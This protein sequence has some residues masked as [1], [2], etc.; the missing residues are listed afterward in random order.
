MSELDV[1]MHE[2]CVCGKLVPVLN[3]TRVAY[4]GIVNSVSVL[5]DDCNKE[6]AESC[7]LVCIGCK[8]VIGRFDPGREPSGFVFSKRS[9]YHVAQCPF[10][11][12]TRVTPILEYVMY[13]Q[14]NNI[15]YEQDGDKVQEIEK[16]T[17]QGAD[18]LHHMRKTI[19]F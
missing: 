16:K 8:R 9:F 1:E 14:S 2:A 10:C 19:S 15:P 6:L 13:C 18:E 7:K 12:D 11:T 3:N 4:S 17:R 5:C